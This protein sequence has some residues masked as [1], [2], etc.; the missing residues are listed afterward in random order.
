[1]DTKI[2]VDKYITEGAKLLRN[3]D[4]HHFPVNA[5]LWFFDQNSDTWK[6]IISTK[7]VDKEGP[8]KVYQ[9]IQKYIE[10]N[11]NLSLND[12]S[13][14]SPSNNLVM[15]L[16]RAVNTGPHDISGIRFSKNTIDNSFIED[17]YIYRMA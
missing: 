10:A 15:I 14:V 6:Y 16:K 7:K 1:M 5:A 3:L 4:A 13:V 9:D 8:L 17:A 11:K 2:L 12:I